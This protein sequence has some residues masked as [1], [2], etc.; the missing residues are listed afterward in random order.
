MDV[1][2]AT[3]IGYNSNTAILHPVQTCEQ[4]AAKPL[5]GAASVYSL[6]ESDDTHLWSMNG[7]KPGWHVGSSLTVYLVLRYPL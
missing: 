5:V 1:S 7:C 6:M 4:I 3:T 2:K